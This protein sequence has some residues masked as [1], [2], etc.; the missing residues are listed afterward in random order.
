MNLFD[1][2]K[3]AITGQPEEPV[4]EKEYRVDSQNEVELREKLITPSRMELSPYHETL[5]KEMSLAITT[6]K[7]EE[8][9][10]LFFEMLTLAMSLGL[11]NTYKQEHA[12]MIN[13]LMATRS[14]K[15]KQL[16]LTSTQGHNIQKTI[17]ENRGNPGGIFREQ[18]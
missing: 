5:V 1:S 18:R 10:N 11:A 9:F 17:I 4:D 2:V 13:E 15:G 14:R 12:K 7:D 8:Y 3:Q 16:E 6:P